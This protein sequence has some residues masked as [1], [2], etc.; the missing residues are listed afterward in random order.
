M[1]CEVK[2][3]TLSRE[4]GV[5]YFVKFADGS[6]YAVGEQRKHDFV[7]PGGVVGFVSELHAQDI[8]RAVNGY[9]IALAHNEAV[10]RCMRIGSVLFIREG[11]FSLS[12]V[13]CTIATHQENDNLIRLHGQERE[14]AMSAVE[15]IKS[16][17]NA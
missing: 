11:D 3:Q 4:Y 15:N 2:M 10:D 9:V 6:T 16:E 17:L 5:L 13:A 14:S 7:V 12:C 1:I 8:A